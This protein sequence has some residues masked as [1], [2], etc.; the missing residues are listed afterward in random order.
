MASIG[1]YRGQDITPGSDTD[2]QQQMAAIDSATPKPAKPIT[3]GD[4]SFASPIA[5]PPTPT[6]T[7]SAGLQGQMEAFTAGLQAKADASQ[8]TKD[9][10]GKMLADAMFSAQGETAITDALYSQDDGVDDR[11]A[12]LD[13]INQQ[14]L[15]EQEGLRREIETIENNTEGLTR[16]GVAGKIDEARRKSLRTQADLAVIQLAKQGRYDSAKA[17]ADRAIAA[18]LE[19][20]KQTLDTLRFIYEENKQQFDKDDQRAFETAQRNR[21]RALDREEADLKTISD[22][23]INALENGAPAA[24]V[25]KMRQAKTVEEA[26]ALSGGYVG[27]Y[28][29]MLQQ[30]QLKK[31]SEEGS[32][33]KPKT[34]DER[35]AL[36][37]ANRISSSSMTIEQFGDKFASPL[38][39][40]GKMLPNIFKSGERQQF[41]QAERDLVNAIL[42]RESGATITPDEFDNARQQYIPQPG[43]GPEV[44]NQKNMNRQQV[45]DNFLVEAGEENLTSQNI[46]DPLGLGMAAA[47]NPLGI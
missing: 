28:S 18:Q 10:S 38:G 37:F 45:L 2:I 7:A 25:A 43:D 22:L 35:K 11:K 31:L 21:E 6:S 19:K 33:A 47:N 26:I 17:I 5:V 16:S 8:K 9:A 27:M 42:R 15:Q 13:E 34:I 32:T 44:I 24:L 39:L 23:S 36:G 30:A 12:E 4:L 41:E 29:R 1:Q 3:P 20:Q 14:I 40:F 46:N